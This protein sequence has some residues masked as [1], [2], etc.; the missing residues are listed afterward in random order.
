LRLGLSLQIYAFFTT[1]VTLFLAPF[2]APRTK[3]FLPEKKVRKVLSD[4]VIEKE[5][6]RLFGPAPQAIAQNSSF[7]RIFVI[8]QI[9]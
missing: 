1:G 2:L 4:S 6:S 7:F 9:I 3:T 8:R 5:F